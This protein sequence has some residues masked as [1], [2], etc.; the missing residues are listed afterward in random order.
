MT[1]LLVIRYVLRKSSTKK[2]IKQTLF[3]ELHRV[4]QTAIIRWIILLRLCV[5][6]FYSLR[7]KKITVTYDNS[8]FHV[9][10]KR[11]WTMTWKWKSIS[12]LWSSI[13][14][15]PS[16]TMKAGVS[17]T[18]NILEKMAKKKK[19][20]G[21]KKHNYLLIIFDLSSSWY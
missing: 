1:R 5:G 13:F 7:H 10:T 4:G 19:N 18:I 6:R 21:T 12:N 11:I 9:H 16:Q 14:F 2:Q 15:V 17:K 3:S 20:C 8:F